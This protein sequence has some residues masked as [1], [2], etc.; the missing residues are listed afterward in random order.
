MPHD[1]DFQ[2]AVLVLSGTGIH[3]TVQGDT[4]LQAGQVLFLRPGTWHTYL[5]C[6]ALDYVNCCFGTELLR[7]EL[8]G[9]L[10]EPLLARMGEVM[11]EPDDLDICRGALEA[12][13]ASR[14]ALEKLGY[15]LVFLARLA[16]RIPASSTTTQPHSGTLITKA[17]ME[18]S[19][20]HPWTLTELA[21]L[22]CLEPTYFVRRFR[23]DT[24]LPPMAWLARLRA[25]RAA[26]LLLQTNLSMQ[27]IGERVG[28]SDL[29]YFARRF[30]AH[31]GCSPSAYR[32]RLG[33]ANATS[34]GL[35]YSR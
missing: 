1:H 29:S 25:E 4:V 30:R 3:R 15:L 21:A 17:Q 8:R 13:E 10:D 22:A 7:S 11:L 2:E 27:E 16:Q 12:I 24:G 33:Q 14:S 32:V 34:A 18:A 23:A 35:A 28:W 31:F 26:T 9:I 5:D 19:L 6:E 20:A